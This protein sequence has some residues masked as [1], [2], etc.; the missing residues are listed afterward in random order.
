MRMFSLDELIST[1]NGIDLVLGTGE[2]KTRTLC[3]S[4]SALTLT[5]YTGVLRATPCKATHP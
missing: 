5:S 2:E 3:L 1:L 4:S